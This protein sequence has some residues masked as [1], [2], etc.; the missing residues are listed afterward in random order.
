MSQN[1]NLVYPN[2]SR[3]DPN[4]EISHTDNVP[5]FN[6]HVCE[7][8]NYFNVSTLLIIN[9]INILKSVCG[10]LGACRFYVGYQ[11]KILRVSL[12]ITEI[13]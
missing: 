12:I 2:F 4:I 9:Y 7:Q 6:K 11:A 1:N 5:L 3:K 13:Y 10:N 8:N